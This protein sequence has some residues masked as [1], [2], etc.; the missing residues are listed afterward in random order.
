VLVVIG[1][2]GHSC[3]PQ[4]SAINTIINNDIIVIIIWMFPTGPKPAMGPSEMTRF[5]L[6]N[7]L[8][9]SGQYRRQLKTFLF[10]L[11][12]GPAFIV[13]VYRPRNSPHNGNKTETKLKQN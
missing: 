1:L 8:V 7:Q 12:Y 6:H 4:P 2:V 5:T 10:R 3:K 11:T 9:L 13:T